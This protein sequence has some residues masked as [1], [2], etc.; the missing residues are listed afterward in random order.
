MP[1]PAAKIAGAEVKAK[2]FGVGVNNVVSNILFQ[3]LARASP[4]SGG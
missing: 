2:G 1:L 4:L 3:L